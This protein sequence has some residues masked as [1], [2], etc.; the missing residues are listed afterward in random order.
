MTIRTQKD[1]GSS[2]NFIENH[3][4]AWFWKIVLRDRILNWVYWERDEKLVFCRKNRKSE[5]TLRRRLYKMNF[6]TKEELSV[7]NLSES[8]NQTEKSINITD[9]RQFL[10]TP[11]FQ[12]RYAI[13]CFCYFSVVTF[14]QNNTESLLSSSRCIIFIV[15]SFLVSSVCP[16][17]KVT[18]K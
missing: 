8:G 5:N 16:R 2:T 7:N 1:I 11:L 17:E 6:S 15:C 3:N 10:T 4:V 12:V 14:S 13:R 9:W 18:N